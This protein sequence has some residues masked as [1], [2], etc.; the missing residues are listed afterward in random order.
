MDEIQGEMNFNF[1]L[2]EKVGSRTK[3]V[4]KDIDLRLEKIFLKNDTLNFEV[5]NSSTKE[6]GKFFK[7]YMYKN[8][9]NITIGLDD[10]VIG[11]N[12]YRSEIP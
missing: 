2:K 8:N 7:G 4:K 3:I 6:A 11:N 9:T 5:V 10:R 1:F 12:E